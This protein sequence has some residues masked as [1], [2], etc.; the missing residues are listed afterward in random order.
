MVKSL[1]VL[2][3]VVRVTTDAT[4]TEGSENPVIYPESNSVADL[5]SESPGSAVEVP[6]DG[7]G[8]APLGLRGDDCCFRPR[9]RQHLGFFVTVVEEAVESERETCVVP[10]HVA[11]HFS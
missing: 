2:V 7:K 8:M 3:A 9:T 5:E 1:R 4:L 11:F 6:E 10:Y